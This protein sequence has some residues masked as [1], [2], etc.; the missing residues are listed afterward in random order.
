ME[1]QTN[2]NHTVVFFER[3]SNFGEP[4]YP[5]PNDENKKLYAQYKEMALKESNVTF[6]GPLADYKYL[7]MDEAILNALELFDRDKRKPW[8]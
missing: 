3:F 2:S 7:N 8:T 6:V 4:Y 5:V 1:C